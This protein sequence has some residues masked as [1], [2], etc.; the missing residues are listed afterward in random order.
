MAEMTKSKVVKVIM[1]LSINFLL[2]LKRNHAAQHG[3]LKIN[4]LFPLHNPYLIL[5]QPIQLID[6]TINSLIR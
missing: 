1:F 3:T 2:S 5:R 4:L 6:D